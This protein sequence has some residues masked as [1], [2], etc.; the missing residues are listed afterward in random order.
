MKIYIIG[1]GMDGAA[2]L[3]AEAV[4]KIRS[5]RC[6]TCIEAIF[7]LFQACFYKLEIGRNL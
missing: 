2:T 5:N 4:E 6:G 3:T 1:T 7:K